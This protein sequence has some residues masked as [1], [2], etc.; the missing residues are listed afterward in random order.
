MKEGQTHF[1]VC[2][3]HISSLKAAVPLQ[4]V[5][6]EFLPYMLDNTHLEMVQTGK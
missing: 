1:C 5:T 4:P 2:A 6:P 3:V